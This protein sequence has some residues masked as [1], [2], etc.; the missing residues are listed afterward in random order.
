VI[1][2]NRLLKAGQEVYWVRDRNWHSTDGTGVIFIS[3][4]PSPLPILQKAAQEIGLTFTAVTERPGAEMIK[5]RPT[6]IGLWDQYG[7]SMSSGWIRWLM[8]QY[9]FPYELVFV[10]AID[11]GNL[12]AKYDVL[13]IPDGAVREVGA[14]G[15]GGDETERVFGQ[16]PKAEDIPPEWRDRLGRITPE[17]TI[18]QLKA[19]AEE[20]GTVVAIGGSAVLGRLLGLPVGNH[21]VEIVDGKERRIPSTKLYIPGSILQVAVDN[22]S[23]LAFGMGKQVDVFFNNSPV[24][25]LAPEASLVGVRPVA[26]FDSPAPLRSGWAWGQAF[27]AGGVA[28][29]EAS[30]GKGKVFLFGPEITF[31]GQPHGT[32]KFL[33]NSIYYAAAQPVEGA[34][35]SAAQ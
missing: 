24:L 6:R 22:T 27:L 21:L 15:P 4:K 34:R 20:G 25:R 31:R 16:Q 12:H 1:V 3:A 8:E 33:F 30:L 11:A 7:G 19:F 29:L 13:L 35:P 9:E 26:W 17:K 14:G 32:F 2:V 18:P 5:L 28:A 10:K 23:P